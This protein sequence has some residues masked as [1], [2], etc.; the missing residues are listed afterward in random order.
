MYLFEWENYF[1]KVLEMYL[2]IIAIYFMY[3]IV[4]VEEGL[5]LIIMINFLLV[6]NGS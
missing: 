6:L 1:I 4:I 3:F 2:L 5:L